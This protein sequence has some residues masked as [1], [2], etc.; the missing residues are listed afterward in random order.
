MSVSVKCPKYQEIIQEKN[1]IIKL[2][3]ANEDH[4]VMTDEILKKGVV[5]SQKILEAAVRGEFSD[6]VCP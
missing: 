4:L 3:P 6:F 5:A 1:R 2:I